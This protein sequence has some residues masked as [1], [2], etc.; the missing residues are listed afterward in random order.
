MREHIRVCVCAIREASPALNY[1][2]VLWFALSHIFFFLFCLPLLHPFS[3]L[4]I[5][6]CATSIP[7]SLPLLI[8]V[9][10]KLGR[11]LSPVHWRWWQ[12]IVCAAKKVH[13]V[14]HQPTFYNN[15]NNRL[16]V[17]FSKNHVRRR[18]LVTCAGIHCW[19]LQ[20]FFPAT[21]LYAYLMLLYEQKS[22]NN[23]SCSNS[24]ERPARMNFGVMCCWRWRRQASRIVNWLSLSLSERYQVLW[25]SA[26]A[27]DRQL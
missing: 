19:L 6:T 4:H 24:V 3:V 25:T 12:C 17:R 21:A 15:N 8:A 18:S 16:R 26:G 10:D 7:P 13:L 27:T 5:A 1:I 9:C 22:I 2:R 23:V 14:E 20:F 11:R